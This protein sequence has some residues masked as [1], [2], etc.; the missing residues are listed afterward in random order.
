MRDA[1][2]LVH[3]EPV[4]EAAAPVAVDEFVRAYQSGVYRLAYSI[5]E[6]AD[7]AEDA[8]Q[9]ALVAAVG[10]LDTFRGEAALRTWVYAIALNVCRRHLQKRR[11]GQRLIDVLQGWLHLRG[12]APARP[13]ETALDQ[14]ARGDVA[15]AVRALDEKHRLP[16]ILRY[17]HDL[18]VAEIA[19]VLG[20]N[21]G[22][23]HSRLFTARERLRARLEP[24]LGQTQREGYERP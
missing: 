6:D 23:V 21:E 12:E 4:F 18:S 22:T 1:L 14:E 13:E 10:R 17:Y 11:S 19:Q 2:Q 24:I 5:L 16:V 15:R 9:E 3:A 7:E 20:I 8:A